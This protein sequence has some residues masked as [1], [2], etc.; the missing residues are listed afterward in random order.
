LISSVSTA[1]STIGIVTAATSCSCCATPGG[2]TGWNGTGDACPETG[3]GPDDGAL[4]GEA[5]KFWS[6]AWSTARL[7]LHCGQRKQAR[8]WELDHTRADREDA[9]E[10]GAAHLYGR[11][12]WR[13]GRAASHRRRPHSEGFREG[14]R[15]ASGIGLLPRWHGRTQLMDIGVHPIILKKSFI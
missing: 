15:G 12:G 9:V 3:A 13:R 4:L 7:T 14:C 5:R 1:C 10:A 6:L 11:G 8:P 2:I